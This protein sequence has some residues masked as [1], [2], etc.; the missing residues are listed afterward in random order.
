MNR[1]TS[2]PRRRASSIFH[3]S[4]GGGADSSGD[5]HE[6]RAVIASEPKSTVHQDRPVFW[7][8]R[9]LWMLAALAVLQVL[10]SV[11]VPILSVRLGCI[12]GLGRRADECYARALAEC[13]QHFPCLNKGVPLLTLQGECA[14]DCVQPYVGAQCAAEGTSVARRR[15]CGCVL[16]VARLAAACPCV[17]QATEPDSLCYPLSLVYNDL[18]SLGGA[19][20]S[21]SF[22]PDFVVD[23]RTLAFTFSLA[24]ISCTDQ[25]LLVDIR[26]PDAVL[27]GSAQNNQ[28]LRWAKLAAARH[29]TLSGNYNAS[30]A[31]A[32]QFGDLFAASNKTPLAEATS[33]VAAGKLVYNL[34]SM[35]IAYA[36]TSLPAAVAQ[37]H[38]QA[39]LS[40]ETRTTLSDVY[41]VATALST[42]RAGYLAL[43]WTQYLNLPLPLLD[44]FRQRLS[45]QPLLVP[46]ETTFPADP[47]SGDGRLAID[48]FRASDVL[49]SPFCYY[50]YPGDYE[51]MN[52]AEA[53]SFRLAPFDDRATAQ[54]RCRERPTHGVLNMLNIRTGAF[55]REPAQQGLVLDDGVRG[56]TTVTAA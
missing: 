20:G 18:L 17:R 3:S 54:R 27:R 9:S 38:A 23:K 2:P 8:G 40:S 43:Y 24:Q 22:T 35:R 30:R 12:P 21:A 1:P 53:Q 14:C 36:T 48:D 52:V 50:M 25:A 46:L 13:T 42:L 16:I 10:L 47:A 31:L 51:A 39:R 29:F 49:S 5:M 33:A 44:R 19:N 56:R 7:Q 37:Q 6:L 4:L 15:L 41:S 28:R 32:R 34:F 11:L 26:V 55:Q 45:T